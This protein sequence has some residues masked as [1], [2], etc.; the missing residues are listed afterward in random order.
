MNRLFVTWDTHGNACDELS[1]FK[2]K[3]FAIGASLDKSDIVVILWDFGFIFHGIMSE[4]THKDLIW[5]WEQNW[6]TVF[7]DGNHENFDLLNRFEE[8][9]MFWGK[10]WILSYEYKWT[11]Y[12]PGITHLKRWQVLDILWRKIFIMWGATSIDKGSRQAY[13]SW[14]PQEI[15]DSYEFRKWFEALDSV[16]G[17]V[18]YVFTHTCPENK[19]DMIF[20]DGFALNNCYVGKYLNTVSESIEFN[21]WYFWHFHRDLS[22]GKYTCVYSDIIELK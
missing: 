20:W 7:I 1:R 13:I 14:W 10:V 22:L 4:K 21:H 18:D 6:T 9:D 3:N 16:G 12:E 17:I 8:V 11:R 2:A 5:L 19:L 15:P